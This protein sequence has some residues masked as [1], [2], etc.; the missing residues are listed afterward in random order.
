MSERTKKFRL[1]HKWAGKS[2]N[3]EDAEQLIL[4]VKNTEM[5][6]PSDLPIIRA[7][8]TVGLP[9][10]DF[11]SLSNRLND[12]LD[13]NEILLDSNKKPKSVK[14]IHKW[15]DLKMR[16]IQ[17]DEEGNS[18]LYSG[19]TNN[20]YEFD[21]TKQSSLDEV[22]QTG[23]SYN[24]F[25]RQV[26]N[27]ITKESYTSSE[28]AMER[29]ATTILEPGLGP[30]VTLF[31][32]SDRK[33]D[34]VKA[35]SVNMGNRVEWKELSFFWTN[36]FESAVMH[37]ADWV[38]EENNIP[39]GHRLADSKII[40]PDGYLTED[41]IY[42][43]GGGDYPSHAKYIMDVIREAF[44]KHGST[45]VYEADLPV[46]LVGRGQVPIGEYTIGVDVIP[47]KVY[48]IS[49]DKIKTIMEIFPY[50]EYTKIKTQGNYRKDLLNLREKIIF[51]DPKKTLRKRAERYQYYE[52]KLRKIK[53]HQV[54]Q[55]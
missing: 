22:L 10:N 14:D 3:D 18:L 53:S 38:F 26:K 52:D 27:H 41:A 47:K 12:I 19:K 29:L 32:G 45:Y 13:K 44:R 31:H 7:A 55:G 34:V 21:K 54:I 40:I 17:K 33:F 46:N 50:E 30:K 35:N 25:T 8:V 43:S 36:N 9:E 2:M 49:F 28:L 15:K 42:P 4:T 24:E 5:P 16:V 48:E 11:V 37:S 51:R 1:F 20:F 6:R 39:Y 23:M